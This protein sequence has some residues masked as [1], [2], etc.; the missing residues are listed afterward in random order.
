MSSS[1]KYMPSFLHSSVAKFLNREKVSMIADGFY[2]IV[3]NCC[4]SLYV[5]KTNFG[6]CKLRFR[7]YIA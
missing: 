7:L 2:E 5:E 4:N 1:I 6:C 3:S